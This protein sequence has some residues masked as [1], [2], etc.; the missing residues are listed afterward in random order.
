MGFFDAFKP[1][2]T[3]SSSKIIDRKSIPAEQIDK[4]QRIKASN[5]YRQRLYKTF[6][7]GYP[8][9]PFI[10]QDRELNTNWIEQAKMFGVTPTKEAMTRYSDGLLPG[11]VYLLY[12]L[13]KYTNQK[14]PSYFEYKYGIDFY[15]EKKLLT[16]N[17]YLENSKPTHKGELAINTHHDVIVKHDSKFQVTLSDNADLSKLKDPADINLNARELEK[18]GDIDTAITLYEKNVSHRFVG[19]YPYDRLAIIYRKKKDYA[20]EI[21]VLKTAID[22]FTHDVPVTRSDRSVKL[23]RF[24]ERLAK[25]KKLKMN[26]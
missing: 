11:H 19:N 6:Y 10:S 1:K 24:K 12:W 21:R 17:G 9:M 15:K 2:D 3:S 25:A 5:C 23:T 13:K 16:Q 8:E 7:K 4:M 26:N 14:A 22:V 18:Q 20:N